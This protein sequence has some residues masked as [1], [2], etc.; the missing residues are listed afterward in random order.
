MA[1]SFNTK[2]LLFSDRQEKQ[3]LDYIERMSDNK[4]INLGG[5]FSLVQYLGVLSFCDVLIANDSGNIHIATALGIKTVSLFGPVDER[6]YGPYPPDFNHIVIKKDL[7]C[8]PC[9][10]NFRFGGC[11]FNKRCLEEISVEEVYKGCRGLIED[12]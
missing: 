8:R 7:P 4:V 1:D 3:T 2:I 6:V 11:N 5:R 10:R 9:Y 12:C